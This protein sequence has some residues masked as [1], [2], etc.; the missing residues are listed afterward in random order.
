MQRLSSGH[1]KSE[2]LRFFIWQLALSFHKIGGVSELAILKTAF[3]A[4]QFSQLA[5]S[6][7]KTGGASEKANP[8]NRVFLL[9]FRS[10][11]TIFS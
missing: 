3:F 5:L 9:A 2:K 7:H 10:A 11:C 4:W 1:P 6:F 8:K